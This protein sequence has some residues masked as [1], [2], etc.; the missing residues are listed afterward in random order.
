MT[1]NA[2]IIV[3][4]FGTKDERETL[5]TKIC[6]QTLYPAVTAMNGQ[7]TGAVIIKLRM[8]ELA[9]FFDTMQQNDEFNWIEYTVQ[10]EF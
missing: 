10:F 8:H 2:Y 6:E 9:S 4:N 7:D 3:K 1:R 5:A